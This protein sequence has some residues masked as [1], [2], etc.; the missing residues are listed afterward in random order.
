M[1]NCKRKTKKENSNS[2]IIRIKRETKC[3]V[4]EREKR[5]EEGRLKKMNTEQGRRQ[6]QEEG[7]EKNT[8]ENTVNNENT[9]RQA[10]TK[11]TEVPRRH[12]ERTTYK[13]K[14]KIKEYKKDRKSK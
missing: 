3:R 6:R 1:T 13:N 12:V 8:L 7:G 9:D 14:N 10:K 5:G 11:K 2:K 4:V